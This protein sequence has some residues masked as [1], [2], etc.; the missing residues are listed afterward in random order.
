MTDLVET[1][2]LFDIDV[3]QFAGMF[4]FIASDWF[5]GFERTE[6]IESEAA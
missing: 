6:L 4:A 1:A 2:E 3:D 5:G